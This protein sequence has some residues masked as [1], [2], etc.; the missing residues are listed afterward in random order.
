MPRQQEIQQ[1]SSFSS[2]KK[3]AIGFIILAIVLLV[4]IVYFSFAK[5]TIILTVDNEPRTISMDLS[6]VTL[7]SEEVGDLS[8]E[9]LSQEVE[10]SQD[11]S[12]QNFTEK[13]GRAGGKIKIINNR[14]TSQ[15]LVKTTRLLS[16]EGIL[17][18]LEKTV[19]VSA[20]SELVAN[21]YADEE[22]AKYN[23]E[24]TRF[25]I[26]GLSESLQQQVYGLSDEPMIGGIK[27]VG[28]LTQEDITTSQTEFLE[29]L[30]NL[31]KDKFQIDEEKN[32]TINK[33]LILAEVLEQ[34]VSDEVGTEV[35]DFSIT[36]KVLAQ[37]AIT[38]YNEMIEKAKE[39]YR[40][41]L[42]NSIQ[43]ISWNLDEVNYSLN[44]ID[45]ENKTA[46]INVTLTANVQGSFNVEKFDKTEIAGFDKKG[47]EYYFSQYP[48]V[49][50]I[51]VKFS[52]FWVKSI[53]AL[54]DRIE[55]VVQ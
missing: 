47:V 38:D 54:A 22:G 28:T 36:A 19:T 45:L 34:S 20:N 3:I 29:D 7:D 30:D 27:K 33:D 51:E 44:N 43:V 18:R 11:F 6:F 35:D 23:I 42:S 53:P 16:P 14:S 13:P 9:I 32:I 21:V 17:F 46:V 55:I 1:S 39:T 15:T 24:S 31:V 48:S 52:P 25:S 12:V 37:A 50:N 8:G 10:V 5:A 40:K 41:K 49:K 4:F 2:F 26:P